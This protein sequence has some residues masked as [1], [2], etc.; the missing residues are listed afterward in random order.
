MFSDTGKKTFINGETKVVG[1]FGDPVSH[2]FSPAM[3][4]AAFRDRK[5]NYCYLPFRVSKVD[6]P[7][8]VRAIAFLGFKGVNVTAPHKEAVIPYLDELSPEAEFL[9]AVNTIKNE[10]GRLIG[11]NTDVD[12]FLY[13]LQNNLGNAFPLKEALLLG[14]GGAARAVS[15]SL[16]K[17]GLKSLV[18]A[19]RTTA[20]AEELASLLMRGGI[21]E[22]G[23]IKIEKLEKNFLQESIGSSSLIINALSEDPVELEFLA[24]QN[25]RGCRAAVDLRYSPP[26]TPFG[27]WAGDN[28]FLAINGLDMLLGQGVKAFEIFTGEEAPS[29]I[30][31]EAL[32]NTLKRC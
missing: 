32:Q 18:I 15:L 7:G 11:Y 31:K 20:R 23:M 9:K 3:H 8:A 28:G 6:I 4:N 5:L 22:D 25:L 13:L 27:R 24:R 21:F 12:G 14:A 16:A 17:A 10:E 26:Q 30:M 2:S 19:N 29:L 1:L